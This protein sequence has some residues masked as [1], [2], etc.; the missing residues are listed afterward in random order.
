[1]GSDS[2]FVAGIPSCL[3]F[4]PHSRMGSDYVLDVL[5][6]IHLCFNPHSRMGSD[7][8]L[9]DSGFGDPVSIHTPAWGVTYF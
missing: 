3:S 2:P 1:M 7:H 8:C 5:L 9:N 4:N 6:H